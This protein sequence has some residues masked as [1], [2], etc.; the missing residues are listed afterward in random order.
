MGS[1]ALCPHLLLPGPSALRPAGSRIPPMETEME[2]QMWGAFGTCSPQRS[3]E[4][5]TY[6]THHPGFQPKKQAGSG[7]NK[8]QKSVTPKKE[9]RPSWCWFREEIGTDRHGAGSGKRSV[10]TITVL[11]PGRDQRSG[12]TSSENDGKKRWKTITRIRNAAKTPLPTLQPLRESGAQGTA[13]THAGSPW[14]LAPRCPALSS[15]HFLLASLLVSVVEGTV[16]PRGASDV[17][18]PL[19]FSSPDTPS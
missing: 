6:Q 15:D 18:C 19:A 1:Q 12:Q 3:Q 8:Q 5:E 10:Q 4:R 11:V 14:D 2:H 13:C 17:I 7:E 16:F 9:D